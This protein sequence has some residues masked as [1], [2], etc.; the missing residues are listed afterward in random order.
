MPR[1]PAAAGCSPILEATPAPFD[2]HD[3]ETSLATIT[4]ICTE[5]AHHELDVPNGPSVQDG[6]VNYL[7]PG[8]AADC[9]GQCSCAT[10]HLHID[11]A[12]WDKVGGPGGIEAEL[13]ESAD[14]PC[15]TSRLSCQI[16]IPDDVN[17]L[18]VRIPEG[19]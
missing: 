13:L 15:E 7:V 1:G 4:Y 12:W 6:S 2:T 5:G 3:W 17:G 8:I 18:A 16:A 19:Y 9:G 14:N 10:C 11:P